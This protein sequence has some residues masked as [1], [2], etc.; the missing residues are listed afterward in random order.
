MKL[1]CWCIQAT[2]TARHLH[3]SS[4]SNSSGSRS[5]KLR[6]DTAYEQGRKG[7]S[8]HD[9]L[10]VERRRTPEEPWMSE[11]HRSQRGHTEGVK[12]LPTRHVVLAPASSHAVRNSVSHPIRRV[13]AELQHVQI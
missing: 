7:T 6:G 2:E 11:S 10:D 12:S 8:R 1:Y 3:Q 5:P 4:A 13:P 9:P